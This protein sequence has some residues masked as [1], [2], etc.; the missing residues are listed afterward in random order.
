MNALSRSFFCGGAKKS[1]RQCGSTTNSDIRMTKAA[2]GP[3][4]IA[5][6]VFAVLEKEEGV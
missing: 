4:Y 5:S 2:T 6:L 3:F 1:L